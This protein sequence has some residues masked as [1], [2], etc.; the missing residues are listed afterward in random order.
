MLDAAAVRRFRPFN[1]EKTNRPPADCRVAAGRGCSVAIANLPTWVYEERG[2]RFVP[3]G[4]VA[5]ADANADEGQTAAITFALPPM[6]V[7]MVEFDVMADHYEGEALRV[8]LGRAGTLTVEADGSFSVRFRRRGSPAA[9]NRPLFEHHLRS[10]ARRPSAEALVHAPALVRSRRFAGG[11][12]HRPAVQREPVE[13]GLHPGTGLGLPVARR[14]LPLRAEAGEVGEVT[15]ETGGKTLLYVDN[16]FM[17]NRSADLKG[18]AWEQPAAEIMKAAYPPR[19]DPLDAFAYSLRNTEAARSRARLPDSP[20]RAEADVPGVRG[21]VQQRPGGP[22]VRRGVAA[23]GGT[24]A[25][26]SSRRRDGGRP[27]ARRDRAGEH[28]GVRG[29]AQ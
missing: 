14:D 25:L 10:G 24:S 16:L 29:G 1:E 3:D 6:T 2:E 17:L 5:L 12:S 18:D 13:P 23:G 11:R 21:G 28:Y 26:L 15:I 4:C 22:G 27:A 8:H 7:G 19:K 9:A 20:G